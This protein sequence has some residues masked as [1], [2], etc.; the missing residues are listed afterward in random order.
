VREWHTIETKN[1]ILRTHAEANLK[2]ENCDLKRVMD[3]IEGFLEEFDYFDVTLR[4]YNQNLYTIL[5]VLKTTIRLGFWKSVTN[6][7][8]ILPNLIKICSCSRDFENYHESEDIQDKVQHY[9]RA[10]SKLTRMNLENLIVMKCKMLS[11]E[12]MDIILDME[13]NVR[14]S[15]ATQILKKMIN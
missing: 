7:Q 15:K 4:N 3:F 13:T 10:K 12:I 14:V 2:P 6:L 8:S 1:D 5:Q 9:K 11:C